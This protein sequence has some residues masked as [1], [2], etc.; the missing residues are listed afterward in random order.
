MTKNFW[1]PYAAIL[2]AL[3]AVSCNSSD[4]PGSSGGGGGGS[5]QQGPGVGN[6]PPA[7]ISN[8]ADLSAAWANDGGDKVT[9]DELRVKNGGAASV[10]NRLW[11]GT[12]IS[13]FGAKNEVVNFNLVLEAST[14]P[15]SNVSVT[16]D[17][18]T[19]P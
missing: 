2:A 19:G 4:A 14:T 9:R 15:A 10:N 7:A 17:T 3:F 8:G 1:L 5:S 16:F 13:V 6:A 12:K 11:N 18:L